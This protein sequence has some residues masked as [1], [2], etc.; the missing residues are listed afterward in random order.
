MAKVRSEIGAAGPGREES[1]FARSVT[2]FV[3]NADP[4]LE[5]L[6]G[7][8]ATMLGKGVDLRKYFGEGGND[9]GV[10]VGEILRVLHQFVQSF[11][12]AVAEN[13]SKGTKQK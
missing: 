12:K 10:E 9:A 5:R 1:E 6:K 13:R 8:K 3:N 7:H 2:S 4:A 11:Q